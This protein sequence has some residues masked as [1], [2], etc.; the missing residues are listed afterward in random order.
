MEREKAMVKIPAHQP[1]GVILEG[2][3]TLPRTG[4]LEHFP[5]TAGPLARIPS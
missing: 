3:I 2:A 4:H 5:C 1:E